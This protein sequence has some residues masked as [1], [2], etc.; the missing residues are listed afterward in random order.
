[1]TVIGLK[2][3]Y[4]ADLIEW[5]DS[6]NRKP[7]IVW[8]ARQVGKTYLI[9]ELFAEEYYKNSYAYIDCARDNEFTSFVYNKS[10]VKGILDYLSLKFNREINEST[11]LIFDEAQE[12]LPLITA[13]K[14]FNQDYPRIPIILTGSMVRIKLKR[15]DSKA[16]RKYLFPVG[17]INELTIY[18]ISFSEYLENRNVMAYNFLNNAFKKFKPLEEGIRD[19]ISK[20]FYEYL[21][22]G[23]MPEV[24]AEFLKSNSYTKALKILHELYDNYLA[25]MDLY[26]GSKEAILRSIKIFNNI[27]TLLNRESKNFSPSV[28]QEKTRARDYVNPIDWLEMAY[29]VSKSKLIKETATTPLLSNKDSIFR[30][31]LSD[32][33]MFTYQS[34]APLTAFIDRD[35]KNTLSGVFYENFVAIELERYGY[36]LYYW[37]GKRNAEFEFLIQYKDNVIPIYINERRG[38]LHALNEFK[39]YNKYKFSIK[40]SNNNFGYDEASGIVTIPYYALYLLLDELKEREESLI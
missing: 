16:D 17:K 23:G 22:I 35:S 3:K 31:Y 36:P 38:R 24:V 19:I 33:G 15:S 5:N 9:K 29:L 1:M 8:G 39:A 13:L 20:I 14:Y 11:L 18:P 12:C 2:R 10:D 32:I 34:K 25:D 21:I 37:N 28:I 30:L 4:L 40:V 27:F 7:L 26:Q 6:D